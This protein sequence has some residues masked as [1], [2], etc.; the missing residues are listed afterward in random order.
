MLTTQF[1]STF[2]AG[3]DKDLV[4]KND[5]NSIIAWITSDKFEKITQENGN[6]TVLFRVTGA[7][8]WLYKFIVYVLNKINRYIKELFDNIFISLQ[9]K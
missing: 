9:G 2:F 6:E 1:V 7:F 8:N 3:K 5:T 4:L